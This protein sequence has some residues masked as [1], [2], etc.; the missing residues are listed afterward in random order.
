MV[1][2]PMQP[3]CNHIKPYHYYQLLPGKTTSFRWNL[4][5]FNDIRSWRNGRYI[6]SWGFKVIR[7]TGKISFFD[8]TSNK[9]NT[10]CRAAAVRHKMQAARAQRGRHFSAFFLDA[11][12]CNSSPTTYWNPPHPFHIIEHTQCHEDYTF[13]QNSLSYI[14]F[15]GKMN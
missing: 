3:L 4:S 10:Q 6:F 8:E 15:C 11:L 2:T 7:K 1:A 5:F 13:L 12:P 9:S 14:R